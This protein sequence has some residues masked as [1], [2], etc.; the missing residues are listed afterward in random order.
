MYPL[1]TG[2]NLNLK[3]KWLISLKLIYSLWI[4]FIA[5]VLSCSRAWCTSRASALYEIHNAHKLKSFVSHFGFEQRICSSLTMST[6]DVN[7]KKK[8]IKCVLIGAKQITQITM[9]N[10][11]E[12]AQV[13]ALRVRKPDGRCIANRLDENTIVQS[14]F[15]FEFDLRV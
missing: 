15:K 13:T 5:T 7:L 10:H 4:D 2:L 12:L 14:N 3:G 9:L 6:I 1:D 11:S 8:M